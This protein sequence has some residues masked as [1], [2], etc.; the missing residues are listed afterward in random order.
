MINFEK[1]YS[2]AFSIANF[3]LG[4]TVQ[5]KGNVALA[6]KFCRVNSSGVA[7]LSVMV[8]PHYNRKFTIPTSCLGIFVKDLV[9]SVSMIKYN[10]SHYLNKRCIVTYCTL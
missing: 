9:H 7:R 6:R 1:G 8:G 3:R 5:L 2:I 10:Y 4:Y